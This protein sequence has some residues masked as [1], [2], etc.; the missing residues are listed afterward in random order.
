MTVLDPAALDALE[1]VVAAAG[2]LD[3]IRAP[4]AEWSASPT[5]TAAC[6]P[7]FHV[8][9]MKLAPPPSTGKAPNRG[10]VVVDKG[11]VTIDL[12]G[13]IDLDA[14]GR[15]ELILAMK[16]PTVRTIVVY[17]ATTSAQRLELAGEASSFK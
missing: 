11:V 7:T 2:G 13:V 12:L 16:F 4:A 6:S 17:T 8:Y 1:P 9:D 14:D 10:V 5:A 3:G 15:R